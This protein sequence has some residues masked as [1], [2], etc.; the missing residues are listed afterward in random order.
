MALDEAGVD[1]IVGTMALIPQVVSAVKTPVAAA[2]G[3]AD[4]RGAVAAFVLGAE[5]VQIGTAFLA[6]DESGASDVY[7]NE[8]V[9]PG[10]QTRLTRVFSGRP[11]RGIVN[12]FMAE[13]NPYEDKVPPYPIQNWMTQ[14]MRRAAGVKGRPEFIS[15]W[16]GQS[17]GL[18]K[19]RP[20]ADYFSSLLE[21]IRITQKNIAALFSTNSPRDVLPDLSG[22]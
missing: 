1:S 2:G 19:R 16:A 21:E 11:A 14:Q 8:L 4:G 5:A 6:C 10:A 20:V 9:K 7:K 22:R 17:A 12:R 13:M 3:I 15:L 18:V